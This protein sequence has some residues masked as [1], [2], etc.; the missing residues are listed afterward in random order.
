M[1]PVPP[2]TTPRGSAP[3]IGR[4]SALRLL[5]EKLGRRAGSLFLTG[6]PGVGKSALAHALADV[7]AFERVVDEVIRCHVG[8]ATN[9]PALVSAISIAAGLG[10]VPGGLASLAV[11]AELLAE[12]GRVLLLLDDADGVAAHLPALASLTERMD[13]LRVVATLRSR[14]ERPPADVYDVEP[15]HTDDACKLLRW[16]AQRVGAEPGESGDIERLV[17][18][19]DRLPL[20][21]ELAATRL[22]LL[23][24]PR[25]LARLGERF[26]LLTARGQG[27]G[28]S[29]RA[30]LETSWSL[31]D[32]DARE[33]LLRLS[34]LEGEF[35][36]EAAEVVLRAGSDPP[37]GWPVDLV[38]Q[39]VAHA[40]L[41]PSRSQSSRFSMLATVRAYVR[42]QEGEAPSH[43]ASGAH[44]AWVLSRL[45]ALDA[46]LD[47]PGENDAI[48]AL[49]AERPAFVQALRW[50]ATHEPELAAR[51]VLA[52]DRYLGIRGPLH[53]LLDAFALAERGVPTD[54]E[55]AARLRSARVFH[56]ASRGRTAGL[57]DDV[58]ALETL[59]RGSGP[60]V[61]DASM[62]LGVYRLSRGELDDA[63]IS[64]DV[65][66]RAAEATGSPGELGRACLYR[67][68]VDGALADR[69]TATRDVAIE[70]ARSWYLRAQSLFEREGAARTMSAVVSNLG[71]LHARRGDWAGARAHG[72]RALALARSARHEM[73]EGAALTNLAAAELAGGDA[74]E[75]LELLEQALRLHRRV[76]RRN[77]EALA[78]W[79]AGLA[80]AD[81]GRWAEARSRLL[82]ALAVAEEVGNA[83]IVADVLFTFAL[84]ELGCGSHELAQERLRES[85]AAAPEDRSRVALAE[86]ALALWT[87]AVPH[88]PMPGHRHGLVALCTLLAEAGSGGTGTTLA[89]S[90]ADNAELRVLA[91]A[92][93][94]RQPDRDGHRD[95]PAAVPEPADGGTTA[96]ELAAPLP[97]GVVRVDAELTWIEAPDAARIDL[98]RRRVLRRLVAHLVQRRRESAGQP[99]S[100]EELLLAGWPGQ[101]FVGDSGHNRFYVAV[102]TLR[103]LGLA[104][105]LLTRSGGYLLD[106]HVALVVQEGRADASIAHAEGP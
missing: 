26:E 72:L 17:D 8:D 70:H 49:D 89:Q 18:A 9:E 95:A 71:N 83:Q 20:A 35:S 84:V 100:A 38:A 73:M 65:S 79:Q 21:I 87:G 76:G 77:A 36:I 19:L 91:R 55:L 57:E 2:T 105:V 11:V 93:A 43:D 48:D 54:S 34:L 68:M 5:R 75:A 30:A 69:G 46:Q 40:L 23:D 1:H 67:G 66:V 88:G 52:A 56:L 47:S 103:E 22:P 81:R 33:A 12:R 13:G 24:V 78:S 15:L 85:I 6:P 4:G 53:D 101:R 51:L 27:E 45:A 25:I 98:S 102:A 28:R 44:A 99:C 106:P 16:H 82:D 64:F 29:L 62:A 32:R 39:L 3:L 61:Y 86:R 94:S 10:S 58:A 14:L 74:A 97:G 31:L 7:V 60:V 42:A 80:E 50:A 96:A 59:V 90:A 63:R 92:L 104:S 41:Q 37:R